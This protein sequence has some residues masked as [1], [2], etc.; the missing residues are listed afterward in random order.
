M[1]DDGST[2][3]THPI[4]CSWTSRVPQEAERYY[5]AGV[6]LAKA[7]ESHRWEQQE[8]VEIAGLDDP[9]ILPFYQ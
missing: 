9:I 2:Q 6:L 7:P 8:I 1:I 5:L 3:R 4:F